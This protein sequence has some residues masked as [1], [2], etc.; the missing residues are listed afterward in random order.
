M[1]QARAPA[2]E[3]A[4]DPQLNEARLSL[5]RVYNP[6]RGDKHLVVFEF[7]PQAFDHEVWQELGRIRVSLTAAH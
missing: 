3:I 2:Q 6:Q 7:S 5:M 1:N 4:E